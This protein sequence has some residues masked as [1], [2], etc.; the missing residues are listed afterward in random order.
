MKKEVSAPVGSKSRTSSLT[1]RITDRQIPSVLAYADGEEFQGTQAKTQLVRNSKNTVVCF[2]D[3]LG[4]ELVFC[5]GIF[6][7]TASDNC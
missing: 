7:A 1:F 5:C 4:Q 6:C 2:R 3:F